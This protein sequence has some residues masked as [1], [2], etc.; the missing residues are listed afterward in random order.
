MGIATYE[1]QG[2]GKG[3]EEVWMGLGRAWEVKPL[4]THPCQRL[5]WLFGNKHEPPDGYCL[6]TA[7]IMST[8]SM[9]YTKAGLRGSLV[10]ES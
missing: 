9:P 10:H 8:S 4:C 3:G 7:R 2:G 5:F 6:S 1:R